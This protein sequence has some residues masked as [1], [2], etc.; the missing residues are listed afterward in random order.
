MCP[1]KQ[2][3]TD[4]DLASGAAPR[5]GQEGPSFTEGK[6]SDIMPCAATWMGQEIIILSEVSRTKT[7][8]ICYHLDVESKSKDTNELLYKTGADSIDFKNKLTVTKG[9]RWGK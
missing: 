9:N 1:A 6:D 5:G 3:G 2:N 4:Q 7:N 8:I